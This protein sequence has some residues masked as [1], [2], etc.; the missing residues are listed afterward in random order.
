LIIL[1]TTKISNGEHTLTTQ[2]LNSDGSVLYADSYP[3]KID[4]SDSWVDKLLWIF[5]Y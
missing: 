2:L 3:I 4:N 5:G 1:D